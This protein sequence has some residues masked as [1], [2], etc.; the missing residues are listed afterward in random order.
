M[1]FDI[2][3]KCNQVVCKF[4]LIMPFIYNIFEH[5]LTDDVLLCLWQNNVAT[6]K[7]ITNYFKLRLHNTETNVHLFYFHFLGLFFFLFCFFFLFKVHPH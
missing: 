1:M 6:I 4:H 2:K 3:E 7:Q 5:V